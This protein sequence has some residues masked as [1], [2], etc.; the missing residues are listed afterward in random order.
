MTKTKKR[1]QSEIADE[2]AVK[3]KKV[4]CIGCHFLRLASGFRSSMCVILADTGERRKAD[5]SCWV[6][7][8]T[9]TSLPPFGENVMLSADKEYLRHLKSYFDR[10][11]ET[12]KKQ[13]EE[14]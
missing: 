9:I 11:R 4:A 3:E 10:E 2:L 12:L 6:E 5:H 14:F 8:G 7:R 13:S 1:S